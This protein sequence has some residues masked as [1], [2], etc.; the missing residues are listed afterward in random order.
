[1]KKDMK[2]PQPIENY[3]EAI[4]TRHAYAFPSSFAQDAV[5]KGLIPKSVGE[6]TLPKTKTKKGNELV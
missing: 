4:N 1:M 3:V 2:L 5:I 6:K